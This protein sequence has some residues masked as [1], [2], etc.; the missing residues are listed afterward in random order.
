MSLG[1]RREP[2]HPWRAQEPPGSPVPGPQP[3]LRGIPTRGRRE[4]PGTRGRKRAR[5]PG[6]HPSAFAARFSGQK[7][8]KGRERP[9]APRKLRVNP[10]SR[11]PASRQRV[12][13][14]GAL[15]RR[16]DLRTARGAPSPLS[17]LPT[18]PLSARLAS[19]AASPALP[20]ARV[21]A[22]APPQAAA[23]PRAPGAL[24]PGSAPARRADHGVGGQPRDALPQPARPEPAPGG[25]A[26][27]PS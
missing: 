27:R 14:E 23:S 13:P 10:F 20:P 6:G 8:R 22:A 21:R 18:R 1:Q 2:G 11:R 19:A 7:V 12:P 3:A 17:L 26:S 24:G 9:S 16:H 4:T 5:W 15:P 25:L